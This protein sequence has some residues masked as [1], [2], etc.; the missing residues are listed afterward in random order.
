MPLLVGVDGQQKMSKS[1]GNQIGVT[2]APEEVYGKTM[3]IPDQAM[4][5]YF[6]LLLG[7]EP[8]DMAPRDGKRELARALV[9][10]LYSREDAAGAERHFDRLFIDRELPE[11]ID[12]AAFECTHGTLH[13]PALIAQAFGLSRSE[14]RRLID[15]GGVSLAGTAVAAGEHDVPCERADGEVLQVGKRRFRRLRQA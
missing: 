6:R 2:D 5:D 13:L 4:P 10:R 15:Q 1:L 12:E 11:E 14:A 3:S 7:R 9:E 8:P